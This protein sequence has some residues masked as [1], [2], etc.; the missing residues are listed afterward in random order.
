MIN[1][2]HSADFHLGARFHSLPPEKAQA[3]R[4]EQLGQ[5]EQLAGLCRSQGCQLVLLSGDLLDRPQGCRSEARAL[6]GALEAMAVPVFLAPG[7]H[8]HLCPGSPYLEMAW[9]GNVH[10]FTRQELESVSLPELDCRVWG[11]GF[12]SMDCP[13]LLEGFRAT[14]DEAVQLMVLHGD[15]ANP[16]AP[17]CPVT[18]A[19]VAASGLQ[20]LALGHIHTRGQL[21]AGGAL[22]AATGLSEEVEAGVMEF[23]TYATSPEVQA[24]WA[25]STGYFP[26][27][28]GAYDTDTLKTSYE[29]M[30]QLQVAADQLLN[31][32]VNSITA[33][34]LLSQ[35]PQLRTD[36]Q[37]ALEAVFN[38][39]DVESAV[40]QAV[41]STNSAIASAN[42]G[43]AE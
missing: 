6:A 23:F 21:E 17:C 29:E 8:D 38:G 39:S 27:C 26:I 13:G 37:T 30:P 10:I 32:N 19:Q 35:L 40:A 41:E 43:V 16:S 18:R 34:P 1:I 4:Q 28:N 20:Y 33:G 12:Q 22:C 15:P 14:G 7:N 9:P 25:V 42:Q 31:S 24:T 11:A 5:L 3:R 2:L 36:L